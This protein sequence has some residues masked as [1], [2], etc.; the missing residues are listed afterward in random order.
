M[1]NLE[2]IIVLASITYVA[3]LNAYEVHPVDEKSSTT[4]FFNARIL[5]FTSDKD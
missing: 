1:I 4:S 3:N 5:H 2:S